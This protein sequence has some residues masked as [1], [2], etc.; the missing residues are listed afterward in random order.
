MPGSVLDVLAI[1]WIVSWCGYPR[2]SFW[3]GSVP[4]RQSSSR[5]GRVNIGQSRG[6]VKFHKM[7]EQMLHTLNTLWQKKYFIEEAICTLNPGL[8]RLDKK[9]SRY[10]HAHIAGRWKCSCSLFCAYRHNISS[11]MQVTQAHHAFICPMLH[12]S[13]SYTNAPGTSCALVGGAQAKVR[14]RHR[15]E[16]KIPFFCVCFSSI[17][18][19]SIKF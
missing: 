6:R 4:Y 13:H 16:V 18:E 11:N 10:A 3:C 15:V 8:Q 2:S 14:P 5:H 7:P 1:T 19:F 12:V 9:L 17:F